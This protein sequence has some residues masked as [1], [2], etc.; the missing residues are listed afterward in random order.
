MAEK[1][2]LIEL[3]KDVEGY[4]GIYQVSNIGNVRRL[5]FTNNKVDK[6]QP[7]GITP[8]DNGHGYLIVSLSTNGK[9][10]N[11]Y[12]HRLVAGAF[13][14]N[15]KNYNYIN[16]VDYN[17]KNNKVENLEWCT[18]KQ[19]I[20]HSAHNMRKP[21]SVHKTTNTGEKYIRK[22]GNRYCV[23]MSHKRVYKSFATL[24]SAVRYRSEVMNGGG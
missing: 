1:R 22:R 12:V 11:H 18:A 4:E 7:H 17:R 21:K 20:R 23:S 6:H 2:C 5:T 15:P 19:N 16:H 13:I 14:E 24:G 9:R 3:W 10:K 8:T